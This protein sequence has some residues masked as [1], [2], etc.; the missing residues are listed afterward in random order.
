M[1]HTF[2]KLLS[3]VLAL[4]LCLGVLASCGGGN[5]GDEEIDNI[6]D[7]VTDED[8][9]LKGITDDYILVGNTAA[10]TGA[11]DSIGKPFKY[12]LEAAFYAYNKA[13]GFR[14]K[15]IKLQH[16]DDQGDASQASTLMDKLIQEDEVFA[17]VGH[18]GTYAVDATLETLIDEQVPMI[19]AAAGNN[20]LFNESATTLG[21][22]GIIPV[23]PLNETEG[24]ML[25]LRAFAPADKGGLG[26]TKVGVIYN[27]NEASK[28]L[29]SGIQKEMSSLT[30]AQRN[31]VIP[32]EV[33]TSDYSAAVNALKAEGCD[34][35][36]LTVIGNDFKDALTAMAN[37]D[38]K[39]NVLTSYN[40]ANAGVFN[41]KETT[42]MVPQY[43]AIF[44]TMNIF[45]Q[46]WVDI[47]SV[48]YV[49]KDPN[50]KLYQAYKG[51]GYAY[52]YDENGKLVET[53]VPGFTEEYWTVAENIYEYVST[54][55]ASEA[56]AM[57]FD[58]YAL[59]GYIAGD[60][61]CQAMEELDQSG[62]ALSRANL[63]YI[64]ES[65]D[66]KICL[67]NTL[68]FANGMRTG[69]QHFALTQLYDA[70]NPPQWMIDAG[71]VPTAT[72]KGS[73]VALY[74]LMS[75]EDYRALLK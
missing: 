38:Y 39:C 73:S 41:D 3:L 33:N 25:I 65:K 1:K 60:L 14:G 50:S 12:G 61:F 69:V 57:T 58:S 28:A 51:L 30:E 48:E 47:T 8:D 7:I 52:S 64:L 70:G 11:M 2:T 36:I 22:K 4:I 49:Y 45:A 5:N 62:K 54:V 27:S 17:I 40:N 43:E 75:L 66:F 34:L 9:V 56:F 46:A 63:I 13:G 71:G 53:G 68:S 26:A 21:E 19:Y 6:E 31:N 18:F 42:D 20:E 16:Y 55:K 32:Q 29:Y 59:A 74:G 15:S 37:V 10:I 67:A 72:H 23:Q 35:V 24:R 44:E